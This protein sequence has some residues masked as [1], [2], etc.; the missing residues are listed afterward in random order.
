MADAARYGG[1]NQSQGSKGPQKRS[2][3]NIRYNCNALSPTISAHLNNPSL[4]LPQRKA[5]YIQNI[6]RKDFN[7]V[8]VTKRLKKI[9]SIKSEDKFTIK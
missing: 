9:F 2:N 6:H 3:M 8:D 5:K 1:Q 7:S 4:N